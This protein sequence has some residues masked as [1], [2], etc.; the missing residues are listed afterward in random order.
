MT[1][2]HSDKIIIILSIIIIS[3]ILIHFNLFDLVY[4]YTRSHEKYQLDEFFIIFISISIVLSFYTLKKFK[5]LEKAKKEL[6]NIHEIDPL[7]KLKN[8][9]AFLK[10][11]E[12]EYKYIILLNIIDFSIF[13]K[14]LGFKKSDKLLVLISDELQE[15]IKDNINQPLFRIYGDEFAFYCNEIDIEN[16]LKKIKLL[17]EKKRFLLNKYEFNIHLNIAY[18][19]TFPK[20]L[21]ALTAFRFARNSI[22]KSIYS[23]NKK[24]D[25]QSNSLKMIHTLKNSRG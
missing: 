6:I 5:D 20:Y 1:K 12:E 14:Y 16:L 11:K 7:T 4:E 17:F 2:I 25:V 13:N 15:I 19:A 10:Y 18:S 21:T 8:R 23:Y 9:N 3:P 22:H 24:I